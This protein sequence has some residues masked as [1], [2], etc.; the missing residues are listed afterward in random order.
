MEKVAEIRSRARNER[1]RRLLLAE[2][3]QRQAIS[4]EKG[5]AGGATKAAERGA[6]QAD[7]EEQEEQEE[8]GGG[9]GEWVEVSRGFLVES[10][11]PNT[12]GSR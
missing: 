8:A 10:S 1:G 4:D 12:T 11:W 5:A 7:E 3:R 9:A 2:V 6:T